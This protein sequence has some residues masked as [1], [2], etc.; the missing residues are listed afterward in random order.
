[1]YLRYVSAFTLARLKPTSGFV[2]GFCG[3]IGEKLQF[4]FYSYTKSLFSP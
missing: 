2:E 3:G 4:R 1:M